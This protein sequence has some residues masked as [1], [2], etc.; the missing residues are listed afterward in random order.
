MWLAQEVLLTFDMDTMKDSNDITQ[1]QFSLILNEIG[2]TWQTRWWMVLCLMCCQFT[3]LTVVQIFFSHFKGKSHSYSEW[4][5]VMS[6]SISLPL[7]PWIKDPWLISQFSTIAP[8]W[9]DGH[10]WQNQPLPNQREMGLQ[11]NKS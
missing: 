10:E 9:V 7:F 4:N 5:V 3:S 1:A 2:S 6:L 8:L 11:R